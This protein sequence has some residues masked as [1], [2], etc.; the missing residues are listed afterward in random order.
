MATTQEIKADLRSTYGAN[1]VNKQQLMEYLGIKT[2]E[3]FN[4]RFRGVPWVACGRDKKY[5]LID[6]AQRIFRMQ[7]GAEDEF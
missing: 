6:A 7:E 1:T 2:Y 5:L 3:V 4:K